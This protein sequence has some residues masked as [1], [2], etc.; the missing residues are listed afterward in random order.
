MESNGEGKRN[1]FKYKAEMI[2]IA[3]VTCTAYTN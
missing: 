2:K 3:S 1:T